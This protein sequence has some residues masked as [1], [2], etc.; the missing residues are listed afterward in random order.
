MLAGEFWGLKSTQLEVAEVEKPC[1]KV[2][3]AI[4]QDG[5]LDIL[6]KPASNPPRTG[7]A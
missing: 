1:S 5:P 3:G 7:R 2:M 6:S 4:L